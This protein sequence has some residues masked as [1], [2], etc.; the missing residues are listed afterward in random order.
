MLSTIPLAIQDAAAPYVDRRTDVDSARLWEGS[1]REEEEAGIDLDGIPSHTHTHTRVNYLGM[2]AAHRSYEPYVQAAQMP[3]FPVDCV[4]CQIRTVSTAFLPCN[5]ACVCDTCMGEN[6]IHPIVQSQW[7]AANFVHPRSMTSASEATA[8]QHCPL[9]LHPIWL[10]ARCGTLA[11]PA[12]NKQLTD[13]MAAATTAQFQ[14]PSKGFERLF[15]KAARRLQ[16]WC[17]DRRRSGRWTAPPTATLH[18]HEEDSEG[19]DGGASWM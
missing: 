12:I 13:C 4:L 15:S 8:W 2:V 14:R 19:N 6:D 11:D 16:A 10:L 3:D 5:H 9:C 17:Q 18:A 7:S 1:D